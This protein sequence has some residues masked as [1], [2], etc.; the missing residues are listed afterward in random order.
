MLKHM[1]A[2]PRRIAYTSSRVYGPPKAS[3]STTPSTSSPIFRNGNAS[4]QKQD[5][6]PLRLRRYAAHGARPPL[7]IAFLH[8]ARQ[9]KVASSAVSKVS[10]C[11]FVKSSSGAGPGTRSG[12][13]SAYWMGMR[14]S[15]TPNCAKME[16]SLNCTI[17][18]II[19]WRCTT[20]CTCSAGR[21]KQPDSLDQLQPF[22]H[23]RGGINGDLASHAPVGMAQ[24]IVLCNI[25]QLL[26]RA[27]EKTARRRP[28]TVSFAGFWPSISSCKHWKMAECSLSTG[29][30]LTLFSRTASVTRNRR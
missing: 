10:S 20:T 12:Q 15:G 5:A 30:S 26:P 13:V 8:A 3:L 7:P 24:R 25:L 14:I 17:E 22:V 9:R 21:P 6:P 16:L 28:S 23:Q 18:W 11:S 4:L 29:R 27:A 1:R 2:P 19:L